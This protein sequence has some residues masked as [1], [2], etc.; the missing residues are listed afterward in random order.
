MR[1]R[2]I[3][4]VL[5]SLIVL[6][7]VLTIV[8]FIL[9]RLKKRDVR[10]ITDS[11]HPPVV[12]IRPEIGNLQKTMTINGYLEAENRVEI[13]PMV[14]GVVTSVLVKEGQ[15]VQ[16][17]DILASID[18]QAL[19]LNM[20]QVENAYRTAETAYER[21]K[22]LH[23]KDMASTQ[24]LEQ[25]ESEYR[26]T[27]SMFESAKLQYDYSSVTS[28]IKGIV[29]DIHI[30][31]GALAGSG[32]PLMT[33]SNPDQ[34]IINNQVPEIYYEQF[35]GRADEIRLSINRPSVKSSGISGQIVSIG[36]FISPHTKTFTVKC[37]VDKNSYQLIPGMFVKTK[38]ILEERRDI[39]LLPF[40]I[41]K[42]GNTLWF[43]GEKVEGDN[44]FRA[45]SM[46]FEPQFYNNDFFQI[47]TRDADRYF[48]KEG[49]DFIFED[50]VIYLKSGPVPPDENF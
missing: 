43:L 37:S 40:D 32:Q 3:L 28:S 14:S 26:R 30:S 12:S 24:N 16:T 45:S 41:L 48:L 22:T 4:Y 38:F 42:G 27:R 19:Q 25:A 49:Q 50:Q 44:L 39:L 46:L 21:M 13:V 2:S 29:M 34:L 8:M 11:I 23:E 15:W 7:S 18:S 5:I 35:A 36:Q 9:V 31:T 10:K 1:N 6:L 33:I 20:E 47:D 17:G